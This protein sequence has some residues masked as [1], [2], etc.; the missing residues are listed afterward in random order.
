MAA[1]CL[2][3]VFRNEPFVLRPSLFALC[4]GI[5][6]L[7]FAILNSLALH[8]MPFA[9]PSLPLAIQRTPHSSSTFV[10]YVRINHR[11]AYIFV[12]QQFLNGPNVVSIF[13]Q[14]GGK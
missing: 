13:Q 1:R 6:N 4:S 9:L 2:Q 10:Q 14:V 3:S 12:S 8:P 11:S 7:E 5:C